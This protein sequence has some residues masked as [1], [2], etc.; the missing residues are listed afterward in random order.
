MKIINRE[1]DLGR[2]FFWVEFDNGKRLQ[3]R[4]KEA[5]QSEQELFENG[6]QYLDQIE[7][8]NNGFDEGLCYDANAWAKGDD[9]EM[10]HVNDFLIRQAREIGIEIVA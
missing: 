3:C 8:N 10:N 6:P 7:V 9:G 2:G 4:L 1:Y 5:K